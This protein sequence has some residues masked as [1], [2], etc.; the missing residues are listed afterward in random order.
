MNLYKIFKLATATIGYIVCTSVYI[1]NI[2]YIGASFPAKEQRYP[3]PYVFVCV[4]KDNFIPC[5]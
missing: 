1:G 5:A 4:I 3:E 2:M